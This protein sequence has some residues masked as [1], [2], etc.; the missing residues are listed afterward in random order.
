MPTMKWL[1]WAVCSAPFAVAGCYDPGDLALEK[2]SLQPAGMEGQQEPPRPGSGGSQASAPGMGALDGDGVAPA[3]PPAACVPELA[4][5]A[6]L[7]V[8]CDGEAY[9]TRLAL[10]CTDPEAR[11]PGGIE[12]RPLARPNGIAITRDGEIQGTGSTGHYLLQA[13]VSAG[14]VTVPIDLELEVLERCWAFALTDAPSTSAPRAQLRAA[15]LDT[16]DVLNVPQDLADTDSISS[17]E[18]SDD[19]RYL[20]LVLDSPARPGS[21]LRL[22]RIARGQIESLPLSHV[23]R[24][25]AHAFSPDSSRLAVVTDLNEDAQAPDDERLSVL[26]LATDTPAIALEER[27]VVAYE[28]GLGWSDA[29]AIQFVGPS[30]VDPVFFMPQLITLGDGASL[31]A[32]TR[33]EI[34]FPMDIGVTLDWIRPTTNGSLVMTDV[35]TLVEQPSGASVFAF[36]AQ[37]LSPSFS[38]SAGAVDGRLS[39]RVARY[40]S[41]APQLADGCE[42]LLSWSADD[43]SLVCLAQGELQRFGEVPSRLL[44]EQVEL[45]WAPSEIRRAV[46]SRSG[47]WLALMDRQHGAHL[48]ERAVRPPLSP[49]VAASSDDVRWDAGFTRDERYAWIQSGATLAVAT[50]ESGEAPLFVSLADSLL[51]PPAC[52]ESGL[53]WPGE[54]CGASELDAARVVVARAGRHLAFTTSEGVSIVDMAVPSRTFPLGAGPASSCSYRCTRFQ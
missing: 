50:L 39:L 1:P 25:V 44:A 3:T 8:G 13:E 18:L 34:L 41:D 21:S 11:L 28:L 43:S 33:V 54:W 20:A 32:A 37:A 26:A 19:G 49:S 4:S 15:R 45:D 36:E 2:P 24:H 53:P 35:L 7:P 23:G 38:Y 27:F 47:R 42:R 12:W 6:V 5:A 22:F 40:G 46:L 48:L 16:G 31:A 9:F 52:A 30:S 10:R 51:P 14:D 17:F 29:S